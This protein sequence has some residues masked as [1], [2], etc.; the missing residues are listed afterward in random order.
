LHHGGSLKSRAVSAPVHTSRAH[1]G[2]QGEQGSASSPPPPPNR[3][4]SRNNPRYRL[5]RRLGRFQNQCGDF[6]KEFCDLRGNQTAS[7]QLISQSLHRL[8]NINLDRKF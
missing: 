4:T 3:Y 8:D 2:L 6:A 1:G 5:T 7:I